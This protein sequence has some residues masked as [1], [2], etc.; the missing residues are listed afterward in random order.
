MGNRLVSP[1]EEAAEGFLTRAAAEAEVDTS[2]RARLAARAGRCALSLAQ[3]EPPKPPGMTSEMALHSSLAC[4]RVS[5]LTVGGIAGRYEFFITSLQVRGGG[6]RATS[7]VGAVVTQAV[8]AT[9]VRRGPRFSRWTPPYPPPPPRRQVFTELGALVD[10]TPVHQVYVSAATWEL[11]AQMPG[12]VGEP[13]A[14]PVA[15]WRLVALPETP[16]ELAAA[17]R[18]PLTPLD[19]DARQAIDRIL[20]GFLA[21]PV[22]EHMQA[23][24]QARLC[25][26]VVRPPSTSPYPPPP[27]SPSLLGVAGREPPHLGRLPE[28][29]HD[30][31]RML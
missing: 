31:A 29:A 24:H 23:N 17:P 30:S 27:P 16:H 19:P 11:L 10:A 15:A 7:T 25:T 14:R 20:H 21:E 26:R 5:A 8:R 6:L 1:E 2:R 3:L 9:T 22:L 18:P 13:V 12:A 4:G 28:A